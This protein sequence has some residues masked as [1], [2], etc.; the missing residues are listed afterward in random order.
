VNP[1]HPAWKLALAIAR[2]RQGELGATERAFEELKPD[3]V[4]ICQAYALCLTESEFGAEAN[5]LILGARLQLVLMQ[6]HVAA[7]KRMGRKLEWLTG[8]L[9]VL[10]VALVVFGW[11]EEGDKILGWLAG[12]WHWLVPPEASGPA[13]YWSYW[14]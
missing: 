2:S 10:T 5:R 6:E 7:Q 13:P 14:R 4:M 12:F 8:V 9:I 1:E 3:A 11:A